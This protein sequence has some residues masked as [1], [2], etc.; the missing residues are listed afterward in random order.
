MNKKVIVILLTNKGYVA[1]EKNQIF[2]LWRNKS[3]KVIYK[4]LDQRYPTYKIH[5]GS[6]DSIQ[7]KKAV[8]VSEEYLEHHNELELIELKNINHKNNNNMKP[9]TFNSETVVTIAKVSAGFATQ[10][11]LGAFHVTLQSGA[12]ILQS[13]ANSL[14]NGEA[15]ILSSLNIYNE[16]KKELVSIRKERTKSLQKSIKKTPH[17]IRETSTNIASNMKNIFNN[18]VTIN[19]TS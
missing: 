17:K 3:L 14:A 18:K 5:L 1:I 7:F 6:M 16:G 9:L 12:D 15:S 2:D 4:E 19:Q 8:E 10:K 13:S 11:V